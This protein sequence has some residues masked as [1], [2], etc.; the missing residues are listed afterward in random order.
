MTSNVT[1]IR[2]RKAELQFLGSPM[3]LM[4]LLTDHERTLAVPTPARG[5]G[6]RFSAGRGVL[7]TPTLLIFQADASR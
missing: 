6:W 2:S 3:F 1:G 7:Q 4:N 5:G